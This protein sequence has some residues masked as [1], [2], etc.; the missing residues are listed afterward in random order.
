[1]CPAVVLSTFSQEGNIF[2]FCFRTGEFLF[3]FIKA[4][5]WLLNLLRLDVCHNTTRMSGRHLLFKQEKNTLYKAV[6]N[7]LVIHVLFSLVLCNQNVQFCIRI[8]KVV[9]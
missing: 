6:R 8:Y 7:D 4:V 3:D 9:C 1:M 2:S 5:H